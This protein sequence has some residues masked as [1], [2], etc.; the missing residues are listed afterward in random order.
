MGSSSEKSV[1]DA[2]VLLATKRKES[3]RKSAPERSFMESV[4][5]KT[6]NESGV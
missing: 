3:S 1:S 5:R 2:R 4:L 6:F